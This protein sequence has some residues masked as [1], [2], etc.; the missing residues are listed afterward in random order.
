VPLEVQGDDAHRLLPAISAES[1]YVF[2]NSGGVITGLAL[3]T[4]RTP[5]KWT[6]WVGTNRRSPRCAASWAHDELYGTHHN[7]VL[8]RDENSSRVRGPG[9]RLRPGRRGFP[10]PPDWQEWLGCRETSACSSGT[11]SA[12]SPV[13]IPMPQRCRP[14]SA[15]RVVGGGT[16]STGQI[17]HRAAVALANLMGTTIM[18]FPGDHGGFVPEAFARTLHRALAETT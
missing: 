8:V 17:G 14:T 9:Q 5:A 11:C 3:V 4:P 13:T 16:E 10:G 7:K 12:Q 18:E 2:G 1:A 15:R 6:R